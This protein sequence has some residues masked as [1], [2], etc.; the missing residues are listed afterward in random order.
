MNVRT[1]VMRSFAF[2]ALSAL[3]FAACD[4]KDPVQPPPPVGVTVTPSTA[5]LTVGQQLPVGA[6]VTNSTN[7]TVSWESSSPAVATVSAQGVITAVAP[8]S[9]LITAT[10]AADPNAKAFVSVTVTPA[11]PPQITLA[12]TTASVVV[13]QTVQLVAAVTGSQNTG[14]TFSTS[15]ASIATVDATGLVTGVAAGTAIITAR[16]AADPTVQATAVIT[17]TPAAPPPSVSIASVTPIQPGNVVSGQIVVVANVSADVSHDVRVFQVR[18]DNEPICSQTFQ[19]P[20]GTTQGVATINCSINTA[21]TTAA[22]EPRFPNGVHTLSAVAL[23]GAGEVVA[24][25]T[26]DPINFN[27]ANVVNAAITF[28]QSSLGTDGFLWRRGSAMVTVRPFMFTGQTLA[29]VTVNLDIGCNGVSNASDNATPANAF[30]VEFDHETGADPLNA[31]TATDICFWLSPNAQD[32]DGQPVSFNIVGNTLSDPAGPTWR[33]FRVDNVAPIANAPNPNILDMPT[34]Q[35][36]WLGANFAFR[37]ERAGGP[38][39]ADATID[40]VEDFAPGSGVQNTGVTFHWIAAANDPGPG[41]SQAQLATAAAVNAAIPANSTVAQAGIPD[42]PSNTSYRLIIRI[43]DAVGNEQYYV[44]QLFGVDL[45]DPTLNVT[46]GP[47]N[48]HINPQI[49]ASGGLVAGAPVA[50]SFSFMDEKGDF[51]TE[52][53]QVRLARHYGNGPV[54]CWDV[55]TKAII[56]PAAPPAGSIPAAADSLQANGV[57][58]WVPLNGALGPFAFDMTGLPEGYWEVQIRARDKANNVSATT[59]RTHLIDTTMPVLNL[60]PFTASLQASDSVD[61]RM[62]DLRLEFG[63]LPNPGNASTATVPLGAPDVFGAIGTA[64]RIMARTFTLT[65]SPP[66]WRGIQDDA[67]GAIYAMTGAGFGVW[68]IARNFDEFYAPFSPATAN[69]GAY[70]ALGSDATPGTNAAGTLATFSLGA[71]SA[72]NN[73]IGPQ[74]SPTAEWGIAIGSGSATSR[75]LTATA[76]GNAGTTWRRPFTTVHFYRIDVLSGQV[77]WIG[78]SSA[79]TVTFPGGEAAYAYSVTFNASGIRAGGQEFFAIGVDFDG[80]AVRSGVQAA[81]I[82]GSYQPGN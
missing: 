44:G 55:N 68:D 39:V 34:V 2:V 62:S 36:N 25:A 29:A 14:V 69:V 82:R 24:E 32:E 75:T 35:D 72:L 30:T 59:T 16:A 27:N 74:G 33:M 20:L 15:A 56:D 41:A 58:A 12:P 28:D 22:G 45:G 8:G 70:D 60:P 13:G 43:R 76:T 51:P 31:V 5:T 67:G 7:Q 38:A 57:C 37:Y 4:D 63:A 42:S 52:P 65:T 77:F 78:S 3:A 66:V 64:N 1:S 48:N 26:H 46:A 61:M 79:A 23:N 18:I 40:G 71:V 19:Q 21:D 53:V 81:D 11:A 80:D 73:G 9:A 49:N 10:A 50:Y 54:K 47:I 17:V 6:V